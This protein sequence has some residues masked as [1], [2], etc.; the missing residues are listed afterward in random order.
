MYKNILLVDHESNLATALRFLLGHAGF[1]VT[2]AG[3][4]AEAEAAV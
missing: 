4:Y 1:N 3:T 2:L